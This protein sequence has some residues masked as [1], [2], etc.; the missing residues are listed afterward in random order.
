MSKKPDGGKIDGG[1]HA[2]TS[3]RNVG[4]KRVRRGGR[5]AG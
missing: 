4:G 5:G 2:K 3:G 1:K